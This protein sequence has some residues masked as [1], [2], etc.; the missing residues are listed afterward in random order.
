[1]YMWP[2]NG[3]KSWLTFTSGDTRALYLVT[4]RSPLSPFMLSMFLGGF[5]AHAVQ[6][7]H[8]TCSHSP[9]D[10]A[11]LVVTLYAFLLRL[12][13]NNGAQDWLTSCSGIIVACSGS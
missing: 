9:R 13:H 11:Q 1:M 10:L 5:G 8:S 4:W 2:D 3:W 6:L 7:V 12:W